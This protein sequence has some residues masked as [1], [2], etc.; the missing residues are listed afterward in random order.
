MFTALDAIRLYAQ[1]VRRARSFEREKIRRA[2]ESTD[3]YIGA[4][5][6]V[7]MSAK[8]HLGL[9]FNAYRMVEIQGGQWVPLE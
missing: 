1:A 4:N 6:V 7:K 9:D 8:D 5:G 3:G 2:L